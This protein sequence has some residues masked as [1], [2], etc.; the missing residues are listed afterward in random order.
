LIV[1]HEIGALDTLQWVKLALLL[2]HEL[3]N[4][5]DENETVE[6]CRDEEALV[7]AELGCGD[8]SDLAVVLLNRKEGAWVRPVGNAD[9][10]IVQTDVQQVA[11]VVV[12]DVADLSLLGHLIRGH[13]PLLAEVAKVE[14]AGVLALRTDDKLVLLVGNP[15]DGCDRFRV[16][17]LLLIIV[18][19]NV[20]ASES[21]TALAL[22][23]L[24]VFLL[25]LLHLELHHFHLPDAVWVLTKL[26]LER[27]SVIDSVLVGLVDLIDETRLACDNDLRRVLIPF[28]IVDER[29]FRQVHHAK[30]LVQLQ[31]VVSISL[32]EEDFSIASCSHKHSL[33]W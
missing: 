25:I 29:V 33:R 15:R 32:K 22:F 21:E 17:I 13:G 11:K 10:T 4:C 16:P 18:A 26:H 20:L 7:V 3:V 2:D 12:G 23:F 6:A 30:R 24:L 8:G 31:I 28:Q 5:V 1:R 14:V 19:L 27:L 9:L